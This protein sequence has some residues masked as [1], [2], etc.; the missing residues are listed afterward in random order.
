MLWRVAVRV[1]TFAERP[2]LADRGVPSRDVWPEYTMHGDVLN[3]YWPALLEELPEYQMV[4]FDDELDTVVG[5]LH[6]G[7]LA[8]D[9]EVAHLPDGVDSAL[10]QVVGRRRSGAPVDTLCAL[11]AEISP[12]ARGRGLAEESL[13]AM[14]GLAK[15]HGLVQL[16][17][18]VRPTW[19]ERYPLTPIEEYV[20]WRRDDGSLLDPWLRVHE[21]VG[22]RLVRALPRSLLITGTVAE[23]ES[24]VGMDFPETGEYVFPR[25]LALLDVDREVDLGTYWEPNVW[26]VHPVGR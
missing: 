11:A 21:R 5:E 8:W 25:G 12:A 16:V 24:W 22:G 19:K 2:D 15:T 4:L 1:W 10:S 9:G 20:T 14:A 3:E 7:P 6:T 18:P 13:H 17:A 23:W 26:V